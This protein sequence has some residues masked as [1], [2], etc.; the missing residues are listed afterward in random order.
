VLAYIE[1]VDL[2]PRGKIFYPE[3]V[4]EVVQR[5]KFQKY[6]KTIE[7]FDES[8]GIEFYEGKTGS[9]VIQ[10]FTIFNTLLVLET[11]SSTTDSKQIL[12][13]MLTWGAAKFDLAYNPEKIKHFAY[14]SSLT[15]Y[16]DI[17]IL[18]A[19]PALEKLAVKTGKALSDIWQEP[20]SYEPTNL[21]VG[22]DMMARKYGIAAFTITRRAEAK[23]SE[24]KYFSE[25]PLP[26]DMHL[27]MLKEF[28]K[29]VKRMQDERR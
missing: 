29:D 17:P 5:Y 27:E 18:H 6:P 8:K 25:A 15:F 14:V 10:K 3:F 13:E 22:H 9:K 20:I 4:Q 26:T 21:V 12:E 19:S 16:S 11:R 28:E 1:S 2:N 7:D 24:N 23:F